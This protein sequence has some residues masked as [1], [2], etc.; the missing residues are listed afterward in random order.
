[1]KLLQFGFLLLATCF[2][3]FAGEPKDL[4]I[5]APNG[6]ATVNQ[7]A[8][9]WRESPGLGFGH[10]FLALGKWTS[11]TD[12]KV[13]GFGFYPK[14]GSW[15]GQVIGP[16]EV[17][18]EGDSQLVL[19]TADFL[20]HSKPGLPDG[21][22]RV[23]KYLTPEEF[24]RV[25]AILKDWEGKNFHLGTNNCV[26][27]MQKVAAEVGLKTEAAV[28]YTKPKTFILKLWELNQTPIKP[29]P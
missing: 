8:F 9:C 19:K 17:R 15:L 4:Q 23:L 10:A 2:V 3:S 22:C 24:G 21:S 28:D 26:K 11:K 27:M 29:L 16:G 6:K 12:V 13:Q 25:E 14:G 18:L 20:F 7:L 1:M 5:L